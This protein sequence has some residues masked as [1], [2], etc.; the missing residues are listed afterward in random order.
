[1]QL[2]LFFLIEKINFVDLFP[3]IHHVEA[4]ALLEKSED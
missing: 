1:M 4:I 2:Q 3:I